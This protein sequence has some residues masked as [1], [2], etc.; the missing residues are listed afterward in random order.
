MYVDE[1]EILATY[2]EGNVFSINKDKAYFKKVEVAD[3]IQIGDYSFEQQP[4][5]DINMLLLY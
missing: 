4:I 3:G 1:D 5:N 2:K